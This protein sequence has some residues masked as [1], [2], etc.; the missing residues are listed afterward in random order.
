[1]IGKLKGQIE[2]ILEEGYLVEIQGI[3]YLVEMRQN[4]FQIGELVSLY[5]EMIIKEEKIHLYGFISKEEKEI[6]LL[7]TQVQ[8]VGYKVAQNLLSHLGC[9]GLTSAIR[10]D[11]TK[12]LQEVPGIGGKLAQRIINELKDNKKLATITL[13]NNYQLD[14]LSALIN[15]GFKRTDALEALQ[16]LEADNLQALIKLALAKIKKN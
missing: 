10:K 4:H 5:T 12:I 2:E 9:E 7:I 11:Q 16:G 13:L 1:M 8:G 14:A 15:L 3:S 6:F